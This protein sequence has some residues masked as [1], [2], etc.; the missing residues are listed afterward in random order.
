MFTISI[1][2]FNSKGKLIQN[3]QTIANSFNDNFSLTAEKLMGANQTDKKSQLKKAA[4]SHYS[5]QNCRNPYPNNIK[6]SY[7][8]KVDIE[9]IIKSLK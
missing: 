2:N 5:L 4:A 8:S 7:T 6:F 3:Q 9:N 1:A